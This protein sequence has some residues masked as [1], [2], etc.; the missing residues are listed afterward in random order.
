MDPAQQPVF[1]HCQGGRHRTGVMTAL[2]RITH[3]SWTAD[4]AYE[5]MKEYRFAR[6]PTHPKLKDFVFSYYSQLRYSQL[7]Q[8]K[9]TEREA[10]NEG[11]ASK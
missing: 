4:Q 3:D 5:E 1:V 2:Y 11:G 10:A 9:I 7:R 6:F 8:P